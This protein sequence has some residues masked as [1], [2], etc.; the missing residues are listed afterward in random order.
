MYSFGCVPYQND[1]EVCSSIHKEPTHAYLH[2]KG[3]LPLYATELLR[4]LYNRCHYLVTHPSLCASQAATLKGILS[5]IK[6]GRR[7]DSPENCP[8]KVYEIMKTCWYERPE[9][10]PT[11]EELSEKLDF[12]YCVCY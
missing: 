1:H 11:F 10:R 7:L 3:N 9:D 8:P 4:L 2:I 5:H 12:D 6:K